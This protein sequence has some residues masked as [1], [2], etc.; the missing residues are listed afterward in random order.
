MKKQ[1]QLDDFGRPERRRSPA[2]VDSAASPSEQPASEAGAAVGGGGGGEA[3]RD[4][5]GETRQR[6]AKPRDGGHLGFDL[7]RCMD[8]HQRPAAQPTAIPPR[9]FGSSLH[10]FII[11][12][13]RLQTLLPLYSPPSAA[14]FLAMFLTRSE[15]DRGVNTFSPEGRS[16]QHRRDKSEAMRCSGGEGATALAE[17]ATRAR[18]PDRCRSSPLL[19]P[20]ACSISLC[21]ASSRVARCVY[22][23]ALLCVFRLFQVEYAIEAIKVSRATR[24]RFEPIVSRSSPAPLL[25]ESPPLIC[26]PLRLSRR[27]LS[28]CFVCAVARN[29]CRGH[30]DFR[31]RG[32]RRR[33]AHRLQA[34]RAVLGQEA[35]AARWTSDTNK[36]ANTRGQTREE[37]GCTCSM[38]ATHSSSSFSCSL[39][40]VPVC[41]VPADI[42]AAMSGFVADARTLIDHARV[43]TQ[44][45]AGDMTHKES[46]R[47]VANERHKRTRSAVSC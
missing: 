3:E 27:M 37:E 35:R 5:A 21:I 1:W 13:S 10:S 25:D 36:R 22:V 31:G 32:A 8:L 15:Y 43:E 11:F 46:I 42:G 2:Q 34:A 12:A 41:V 33:E 20:A 38:D 39:V 9:E 45:R 29:H 47:E 16:E 4:G 30:S 19:L 26:P 44:V 28:V 17:Q 23:T 24:S 40:D 6:S 18:Q 7:H 14:S